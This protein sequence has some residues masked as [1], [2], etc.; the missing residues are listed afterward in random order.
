MASR[1]QAIARISG[2]VHDFCLHPGDTMIGDRLRLSDFLESDR[3]TVLKDA[4]G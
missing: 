4:A 2:T 1:R 3:E